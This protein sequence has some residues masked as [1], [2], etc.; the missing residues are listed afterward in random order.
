MGSFL[1]NDT[2]IPNRDDGKTFQ[3]GRKMLALRSLRQKIRA[4]R[5]A[6]LD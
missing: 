1:A 4:L 3:E 6:E 2:N 5:M